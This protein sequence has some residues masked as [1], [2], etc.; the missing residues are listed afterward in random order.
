MPAKVEQ[1]RSALSTA[2]LRLIREPALRDR[3][4]ATGAQRVRA[5]FDSDVWLDR[6]A[7]RFLTPR[8]GGG[9]RDAKAA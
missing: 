8:S 2:L 4:G 5:R 7:A 3:L 1:V 9:A 6:L